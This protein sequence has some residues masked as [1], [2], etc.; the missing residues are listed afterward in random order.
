VVKHFLKRTGSHAL[1]SL[2][3][4]LKPT[5]SPWPRDFGQPDIELYREVSPYTMTT[6]E[7]VFALTD[8]VRYVVASHVAGAIVECGVW[9]GGSMM[10]VARTLLE[11]GRSDVDLYLFDTFEGMPPPTEHDVC[12]TGQTAQ[13]LLA[14]EGNKAESKL[15]ARATL[16]EVR[17]AIGTIP[18]PQSRIYFVKGRVEETIPGRAPD[19]IAILRLDTDW[20]EST[21]HELIHLYPRLAPGGVL[22]I[23]DY[24]CWCGARTATDDYFREHGPAPLLVRIDDG[25]VR[26]AIKR[27]PRPT[28]SASVGAAGSRRERN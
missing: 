24:G 5:R 19:R 2:G 16:D 10:A 20:Y 7:A 27:S 4:E 17:R 22:I 1:R 26:L 3:Y 13:E 18:Y 12:W 25:G 23:D 21:R 8:A 6:P 28:P 14:T 11:L 9:R 15:W